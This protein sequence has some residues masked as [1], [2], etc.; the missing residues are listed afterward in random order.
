MLKKGQVL[1]VKEKIGQI[2]KGIWQ[3]IRNTG[4]C[5]SLALH[6]RKDYRALGCLSEA[7]IQLG[8]EHKVIELLEVEKYKMQKPKGIK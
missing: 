1:E 7:E 8:L 2:P 3:V 4:D 5:Y 6:K